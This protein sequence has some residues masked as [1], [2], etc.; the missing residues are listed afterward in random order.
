LK[1]PRDYRR[2]LRRR[3]GASWP[4]IVAVLFAVG[5]QLIENWCYK[6]NI[7]FRR[8]TL[9][10]RQGVAVLMIAYCRQ[11]TMLLSVR[12]DSV[13][14]RSCDTPRT[15]PYLVEDSGALIAMSPRFL[16]CAVKTRLALVECLLLWWIITVFRLASVCLNV[17][18]RVAT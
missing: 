11:I 9:G 13:A 5:A 3:I 12:T 2:G 15:E 7:Y 8:I 10:V 18:R 17:F 4:P 1:V 14:Y 6:Q 16:P